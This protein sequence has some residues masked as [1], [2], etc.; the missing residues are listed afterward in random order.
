MFTVSI[1]NTASVWKVNHTMKWF[2]AFKLVK[3]QVETANS[4]YS[5]CKYATYFWIKACPLMCAVM[6]THDLFIILIA[7][8]IHFYS[9]Y[10]TASFYSCN[11]YNVIVSYTQT[12]IY[13]LGLL[14]DIYVTSLRFLGF[15]SSPPSLCSVLEQE[16][17][18]KIG[19]SSHFQTLFLHTL[20]TVESWRTPV[21]RTRFHFFLKQADQQR[22]KKA[23]FAPV[24]CMAIF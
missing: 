4:L 15:E 21:P 16:L 18:I 20:S 3:K 13:I 10:S 9:L 11:I 5:T 22:E 7:W 14:H 23:I 8:K 19:V 17:F 2:E 24:F 12:D 1:R 6:S